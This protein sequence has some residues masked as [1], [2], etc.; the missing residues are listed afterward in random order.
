MRDKP[1][2]IDRVTV[3]APAHLIVNSTCRQF[4]QSDRRQ[5]YGLPTQIRLHPLHGGT[6]KE[7][8]QIG[9]PGKFWCPAKATMLLV[10]TL[11]EILE[12]LLERHPTRLDQI[13]AFLNGSRTTRV[14]LPQRTN[15]SLRLVDQLLALVR[16]SFG[17]GS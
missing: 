6:A 14:I 5:F 12:A 16:P 7:K 11:V 9:G 13:H 17:D 10:K 1:A 8:I 4:L 15:H 2:L 3:E